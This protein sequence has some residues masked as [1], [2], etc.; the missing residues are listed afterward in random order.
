MDNQKNYY[1]N[2]YAVVDDGV[3]IGEGTNTLDV[4]TKKFVLNL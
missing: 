3:E 1:I 2:Q 4:M